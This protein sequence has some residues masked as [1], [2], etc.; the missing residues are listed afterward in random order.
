MGHRRNRADHI[1]NGQ[2]VNEVETR[3]V[4][5]HAFTAT[6]LGI[7]AFGVRLQFTRD[8]D[9]VMMVLGVQALLLVYGLLAVGTALQGLLKEEDRYWMYGCVLVSVVVFLLGIGVH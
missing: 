1:A 7:V 6:F 3:R 5:S 2:T 9:S 4:M 8:R